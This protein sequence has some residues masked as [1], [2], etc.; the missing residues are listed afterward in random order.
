M[1]IKI[2]CPTCEWEPD[3]GP[4]WCCICGYE[5]NTFETSG[6]CPACSKIWEDTQCPGPGGPG[7]CGTW[8]KHIDWYRNLDTALKLALDKTSVAQLDDI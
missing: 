1:Q 8:S 6:K 3:G 5:W 7:G 2:A 4:H